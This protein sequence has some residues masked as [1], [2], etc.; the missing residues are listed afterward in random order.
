VDAGRYDTILELLQ[1]ERGEL[2]A[3]LGA[4][5]PDAWSGATGCPGWSVKDIAAHVLSDDVGILARERDSFRAPGAPPS[6]SWD[7]LVRFVNERNEAWVA[8]WRRVS[9]RLLIDL[10]AVTGPSLWDFYRTL[11]ADALGESVSWAGTQPAPNWL[12]V[13]REYTERWVHQQQI[14]DATGTPGLREARWVR[15]LLDTFA[16]SLPIALQAVDAPEGTAVTLEATGEGGGRWTVARR[17]EGWQLAAEPTTQRPSTVVTVE[18]DTLW[19]LYT[20]AID[21]DAARARARIE[22]DA[23]LGERLLAARAIIA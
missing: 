12:R 8:A 23:A 4:L 14:R 5:A 19:R 3:L 7:D 9:P 13:A 22:G 16:H 6:S 21:R 2:L 10:L 1:S 17:G 15:P 20:K 11:D 18:V